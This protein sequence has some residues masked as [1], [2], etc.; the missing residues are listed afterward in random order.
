MKILAVVTL[1]AVFVNRGKSS[2][3]FYFRRLNMACISKRRDRWVIDFYDNRGKRRW[4]TLP[5]D[6]TK[7]KA[8]EAMRD[9][10]DQVKR[11]IFLPDRK[12][13][14][15]EKVAEDWLEY[16]KAN[17]RASTWNMYKGHIENHFHD[18]NNIRIN[19]ISTSTVEKFIT[20]RLNQNMNITTLRKIIVTFN[21]IMNYSVRHRY[22]DYNPVRDAERPKGQGAEDQDT[23]KILI[24]VQINALLDAEDDLKYKT[25][26][27]L[28]IMSGARQGELFGLKWTD[29]DWFNNQIYI[30]RTFNNGSWYNPKSKT[31]KRKIDIGPSMMSELKKWHKACL[32]C[33][34]DLVFPNQ[35]GKPLDHGHLLSRHFWKAL[36]KAEIP[37]IRFHDLRHTYASLLIEQGENIKYIQSQLGHSSPTVTLDVYAHLMKPVNQESA[38]RLENTIFQTT[39]SKMVAKTKEV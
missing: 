23:I 19:Q 33:E 22:I 18:V 16:K 32:K 12:V 27:R 14:V 3:A 31:S 26:Y 35:E 29:V 39:G 37:R 36:K 28:A 8:W 6:T 5:K 10:E 7:T 4:K 11:G 24:P 15:F 25:I 13:P 2:G 38:C 1:Q 17:I 34:L 21:Q 20:T 30:Q 9:I